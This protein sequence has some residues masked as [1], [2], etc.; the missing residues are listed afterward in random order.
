[1]HDIYIVKSRV[2]TW[3]STYTA[4]RIRLWGKGYLSSFNKLQRTIN[5]LMSDR[6]TVSRFSVTDIIM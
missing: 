4:Q 5:F 1:M 2:P 3:S 6:Y